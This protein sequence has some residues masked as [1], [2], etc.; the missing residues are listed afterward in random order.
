[1]T[2]LIWSIS[3][4]RLQGGGFLNRDQR[5][6]IRQAGKGGGRLRPLRACQA[7]PGVCN[8]AFTKKGLDS[9]KYLLE[10]RAIVYRSI[11]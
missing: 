3:S 9:P 8:T 10:F 5:P 6:Q 2:G 4:P 7:P 1:M 11:I